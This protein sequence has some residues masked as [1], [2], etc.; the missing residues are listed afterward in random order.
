MPQ[1]SETTRN[2][3]M[4][5]AACPATDPIVG[6]VFSSCVPCASRARRN[7]DS[8]DLISRRE[9]LPSMCTPI[10]P[11]CTHE[12]ADRLRCAA[13]IVPY[14]LGEVM[15]MLE[16]QCAVVRLGLVAS[17]LTTITSAGEN[18]KEIGKMSRSPSAPGQCYIDVHGE[19]PTAVVG[20]ALLVCAT[21][22]SSRAIFSRR[23]WL[24]STRK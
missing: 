23:R 1:R 9:A 7:A 5:R 13:A 10:V 4:S 8:V 21:M 12:P 18:P 20:C 3:T 11:P 14:P 6:S 22:P 17:R 16:G 19:P 15:A 2:Q 24:V